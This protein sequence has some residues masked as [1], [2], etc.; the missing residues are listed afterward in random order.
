MGRDA[1]PR[2][3]AWRPTGR[4]LLIYPVS[5]AAALATVMVGTQVISYRLGGWSDEPAI[6]VADYRDKLGHEPYVALVRASVLA[7]KDGRA[8]PSDLTPGLLDLRGQ[9][10][11]LGRCDYRTGTTS[12]ARSAT[13]TPIAASSCWATPTPAR[14]RRRSRR[15]AAS[16]ATASTSSSTAGARPPT[17]SRSTATPAGCGTSVRR[18]R[19]GRGEH[20]GPVPGAGRRLHARGASSST[21]RRATSCHRQGQRAYLGAR[22]RLDRAFR[23]P[24]VDAD[25]VYVVG[26]TPKLPRETGVCL[27]YGN[28]DLGTAL[29]PR[30]SPSAR[31]ESFAAARSAGVGVVDASRWFCADDLCP[32]VVGRFITMR[33]SEHMT[34]DYSRWLASPWPWSSASARDP[35]HTETHRLGHRGNPACGP[36]KTPWQGRRRAHETHLDHDFQSRHDRRPRAG[37]RDLEIL[38]FERQWWKYGGGK[39]TAIRERFDMSAIRYY[40]RLNWIIDQSQAMAH[41]PLLVRRLKRTRLARQRHRSARRLG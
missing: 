8:V 34:P 28:P 26:N 9:T 1:L 17:S 39:E 41:D 4:A 37:E 27:S 38:D 16:T 13:R 33:D 35:H 7:A 12:C 10:A 20:H 5:V 19:T 23:G 40:Q 36:M 6:S 18:S 30:R 2:G 32:S 14:S 25:E 11:S 22:A 21:R 31:P 15:S 3:R 24:H 29:P